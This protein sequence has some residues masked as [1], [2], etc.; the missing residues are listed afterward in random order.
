[1]V[2]LCS[3]VVLGHVLKPSPSIGTAQTQGQ[4]DMQP[5]N[6]ASSSAGACLYGIRIAAANVEWIRMQVKAEGCEEIVSIERRAG[7]RTR[8]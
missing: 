8:A 3:R 6:M 7:V 1:M 2:E 5:N 4:K